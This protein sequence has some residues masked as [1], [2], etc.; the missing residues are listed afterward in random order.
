MEEACARIEVDTLFA[1]VNIPGID[2]VHL[3]YRGKLRDSDHAAGPES[4]ETAL[5]LEEDIPWDE[6][7]FRSVEYCLRTYLADRRSGR[8]AFHETELPPLSGY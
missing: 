3:F 4:L 8:F 7:A 5:F 1:L 2:Q 6:L